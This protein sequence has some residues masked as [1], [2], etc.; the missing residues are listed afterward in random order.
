MIESLKDFLVLI[1]GLTRDSLH[2]N[3]GLSIFFLTA[4]VRR[5]SPGRWLPLLCVLVLAIV[6][7]VFDLRR[8]YLHGSALNWRESVRDI[9]NTVFWPAV[10]FLMVRTGTI[11]RRQ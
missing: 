1:S 9:A 2:T 6:N 11:F 10:L 7:E 3:L 4:L 8:D 5:I